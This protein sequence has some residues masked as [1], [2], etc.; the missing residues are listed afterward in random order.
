MIAVVKPIIKGE[1]PPAMVANKMRMKNG[2]DVDP[3]L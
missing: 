3:I 1:I 2:I